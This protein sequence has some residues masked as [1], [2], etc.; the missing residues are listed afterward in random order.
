MDDNNLGGRL[1][2]G[3]ERERLQ[4]I[5]QAWAAKQE[6]HDAARRETVSLSVSALI[7]AGLFTASIKW[8]MV[9]TV[10]LGVIAGVNMLGAVAR[11]IRDRDK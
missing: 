6:E 1:P 5:A 11:I 10:G 4:N 8:P 9:G 7:F 2:E 3:E